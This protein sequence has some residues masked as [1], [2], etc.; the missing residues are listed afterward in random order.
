MAKKDKR[1]DA[2]IEKSA[3]FAKPILKHLRKLVHQGCPGVTET[4]KW[5]MPSF[6]YKGPFCSMA[7]FKQHAVFG[8]WK[9]KLI[10]DPKNY[11]GDIKADGGA[12]MGNM[13]RITSL[14]DLP[15]DSVILGFIK[16][17][18]KL[19]DDGIKME[20]TIKN[21]ATAKN[22]KPDVDFEAAL[23]KNKKA[24]NV[25]EEWTPGKK[26]EYVDWMKEAKTEETKLK[27]IK[28]AV[29]WISEGKIRNWK[30]VK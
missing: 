3:D 1:I 29:E 21:P 23:K 14:K 2:Y 17:A 27:R 22:T 8:F 12:S 4:V 15:P 5:G 25:W 26:K 6:E 10:K 18:V 16:Q 7:S 30:Y 9:Y 19:N 13:G 20:K 11:L 28:T 24:W